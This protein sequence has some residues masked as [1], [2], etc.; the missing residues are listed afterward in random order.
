MSDSKSE[1]GTPTL[2]RATNV[3][4]L[5]GDP[6]EESAS[7]ERKAT[8]SPKKYGRPSSGMPAMPPSSDIMAAFNKM[9]SKKQHSQQE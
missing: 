4:D 7:A 1:P 8:K 5:S 9:Q 2:T 3:P 6:S